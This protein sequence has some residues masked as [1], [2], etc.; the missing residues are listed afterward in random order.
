MWINKRVGI[1]IN[2]ILCF[3]F[4]KDVWI[5]DLDSNKITPPIVINRED[6][7][8]QLP[9]SESLTLKNNL[10]SVIIIKT[11]KIVNIIIHFI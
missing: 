3:R 9:K 4:P 2:N 7:I 11:N 10:K 6:A 5:V 8:P 1:T